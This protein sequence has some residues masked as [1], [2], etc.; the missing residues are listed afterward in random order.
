MAPGCYDPVARLE[1]MDTAGVLASLNFPS[2][3]RFCG[4]LFWEGADKD[5]G[6]VRPGKLADLVLID[7]D[8]TKEISDVRKVALTIKDGVI[9]DPVELDREM[10]IA[11]R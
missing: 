4:Q 6:L 3:P 10:G 1:D 2:A 5:L 11:P 9:Y 8:P 7:G